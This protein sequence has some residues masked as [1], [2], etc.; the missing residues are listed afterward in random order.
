MKRNLWVR[1]A[2][3]ILV[4]GLLV[5]VSCAKKSVQTTTADTAVMA[6]EEA[7]RLAAE[8]AAEEARQREIEESRLQGEGLTAEAV[9]RE[10]AAARGRFEMEDIY[11]AFDRSDLSEMAQQVLRDKVQWLR[12]NPY[13]TVVVEG[14]CDE[15]GT[16]EYNLAL[17]ERRAAG[18]LAFLV[19]L[20]VEAYRL[21]A[22]SFGEER[23][24][25]KGN[26]EEAWSKNR[27][28][29]FIIK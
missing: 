10:K 19:D 9:E 18:A 6:E 7:A 4:S 22:I 1:L 23:P 16:T 25:E 17:G 27:R 14:H 29:H 24:I 5:T 2:L 20:G 12:D 26:T 8:K 28:A 11:F 13:A 3:L 15:R 21:T